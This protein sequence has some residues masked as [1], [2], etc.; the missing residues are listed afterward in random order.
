MRSPVSSPGHAPAHLPNQFGNSI[1]VFAPDASGSVA[2]VA[3]IA[4]ATTGLSAPQAVAV[5]PPLS[6]LTKHL[7]GGIVRHLYDL[8]LRVRRLAADSC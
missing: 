1:A 2:P 4:G 3:T 7:P 5:V 6:I 8:T